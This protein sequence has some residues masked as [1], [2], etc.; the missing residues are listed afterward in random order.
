MS[1]AMMDREMEDNLAFAI[2]TGFR[3]EPA[4]EGA[5]ESGPPV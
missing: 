1:E 3:G 5:I 2:L 4:P